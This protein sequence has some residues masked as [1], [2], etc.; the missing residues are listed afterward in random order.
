MKV[1]DLV[2]LSDH[3]VFDKPDCINSKSVGII[4]ER[5]YPCG[6]AWVQWIGRCDWDYMFLEDLEIASES[7]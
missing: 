1:G 2:R 4:L 5:E 6:M 3:T 7:S